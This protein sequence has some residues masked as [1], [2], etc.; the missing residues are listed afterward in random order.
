M[1]LRAMA[2]FLSG[3]SRRFKTI[4]SSLRN[5]FDPAERLVALQELSEVLSVS[6]EDSLAGYFP[7]E[8]FVKELIALL[9]GN[10]SD[11][12]IESGVVAPDSDVA[13][14][15]AAA[16][17][18]DAGDN[19]EI[20]LLAAR[21]LTNLMEAMPYATHSVVT[22]GAIPLLN[23]KLMF[24]EFI[25]LAEQVLQTLE[26]ISVD[27]PNAIVEE[28]GL[29]AM[30]QY[31]DFF[32]I[33][34][35]RTAMNAVSNCCR[36][37]NSDNFDKVKDAMSQ[38]QGM[39]AS[40]DRRLKE[41]AVRSVVR[42][43]DS[44]KAFPEILETLI[45]EDV[46][47]ATK[48]VLEPSAGSNGSSGAIISTSMYT[49][50]VK[51]LC[52]AS[53][54][55][56]QITAHL[57]QSGIGATLYCI[58]TGSKAADTGNL[59]SADPLSKPD[60]T[61]GNVS[62]SG[63]SPVVKMTLL[64][65][66]STKPKEQIQEALTLVC[67][68]LPPLPWTDI[69]D[70]RNYSEKALKRKKHELAKREGVAKG[71]NSL[72]PPTA[73]SQMESSEDTVEAAPTSQASQIKKEYR[74]GSKEAA[75][76]VAHARRLEM[77]N[78]QKDRLL[79]L[80]AMILPA[81]VDI[82]TASITPSIRSKAM[83][84]ILKILAFADA[85]QLEGLL[86]SVPMSTFVAGVLSSKDSPTV[87]QGSLQV[88]ELL[89]T[90]L[91][92]IY[93]ALL[94]REGV[95]WEVKQLAKQPVSD[96]G[97]SNKA[98]GL[99]ADTLST[100]SQNTDDSP[101]S[102][103][104]K[105]GTVGNSGLRQV[106]DANVL[107]ARMV[108]LVFGRHKQKT[109]NNTES[110]TADS[111]ERAS[112]L[113]QQIASGSFES[114]GAA[115]SCLH[116]AFA[117]LQSNGEGLSGF[118]VVKSGLI[119][120][121]L[122]FLN[123]D[124]DASLASRRKGLLRDTMKFMPESSR[125]LIQRLQESLS[126]LERVEMVSVAGSL[127]DEHRRSPAAALS[128]Q[129]RL[130]LVA[131]DPDGIPKSCNNIIVSIHAVA[132]FGSLHDFLRPK[133][134]LGNS[135]I[136]P[137]TSRLSS[138]L[139]AFAAAAQGQES[140]R[141]PTRNT[142]SLTSDGAS[143]ATATES[144]EAHTRGVASGQNSGSTTHPGQVT[145]DEQA[146]KT[147][148][149]EQGLLRGESA[150]LADALMQNLMH[151]DMDPLDEDLEELDI[152]EREIS[153][154]ESG[155][156]SARQLPGSRAEE[157]ETNVSAP[158]TANTS[159][160]EPNSQTKL[161]SYSEAVQKPATDWHLA[162]SVDG[163]DVGLP[164]TIFSAIYRAEKRKNASFSFERTIWQN[165]VTVRFRKVPGTR[166]RDHEEIYGIAA[167]K[168]PAVSSIFPEDSTELKILRL[169]EVLYHAMSSLSRHSS[170]SGIRHLDTSLFINNKLTA[171]LNRQ[172]EEPL[173]V[174]S[175]SL[176][177]WAV[178]LPLEYPFLFP[179]ETRFSFLQSTSFGYARLIARWQLLH[180]GSDNGRNEDSFGFLSRLQRQKVRISRRRLLDSAVKIFDLYASNSS[181][182]EVE[183]FDEVG[184]GLGP[185]LEFYSLVSQDF[186]LKE[187]NIWLD[188]Q[189]N[190]QSLHVSAAHG[191]YPIPISSSASTTL[192][193]SKRLGLF[194]TLGTFVAKALLDSR[195][196]QI[197]FS[198]LFI[199]AILGRKVAYN[200]DT[201][202]QVDGGLASSLKAIQS[203]AP[204]DV[205]TLHL[206]FTLPGDSNYEL[207]PGGSDKKVS[208]NNVNDYISAV[209]DAYLDSGIQPVVESFRAGFE[210]VFMLSSLKPFTADEL[211]L[212][213]GN[214]QEDW[215]A[216]TLLS[217]IKP[218]HGFTPESEPYRNLLSIM[219][220]FTDQ[221]RRTFLQ[222]L[223]GSPKLPIGG[224]KALHPQ[225]TVVK[226]PHEAPLKPDDYLPSVMTCVN[227]LKLPS[228]SGKEVMRQRLNTAM[229]EGG[230]AFHLS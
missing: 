25:D 21:C 54:A 109:P 38:I 172:L 126:R 99:P 148:Q 1:N 226:R 69:F 221:E 186:A 81:L 29:M 32:N 201:L 135:L 57:L 168:Q 65:N 175:T 132:S 68:L 27:Y 223:T 150:S 202:A 217:N 198:R 52:N 56:P 119:N 46:C 205:A 24:I 93:C 149:R 230:T 219:Q 127:D 50:L 163:E 178:G 64:Q 106:K 45:T 196:V 44:Y 59:V 34:V 166:A 136:G 23:S 104:P 66:L 222:W 5:R 180:R 176:P 80:S 58:L 49:D 137:G 82:H 131:D 98:I 116:S 39:L 19:T 200:L 204:E 147:L 125:N 72:E 63:Q 153:P 167:E 18:A 94:E 96:T 124:S 13:A 101:A 157:Q 83:T 122:I 171:K 71:R 41:S 159:T 97:M 141:E 228:Y 206:D 73:N 87:I 146:D 11:A 210:K 195:I 79:K 203:V 155:D 130:R 47:A 10:P 190:P 48:F 70:Q 53:K 108:H 162:F 187:N 112:G 118:E 212:L 179:F 7:T 197:D 117:L 14:A 229:L 138:V 40:P 193:G 76:Q 36:K 143:T 78:E 224:F 15:L 105:L 139:A 60:E 84:A 182:L 43:I 185:T 61:I 62:I 133:I 183:Y 2:G 194:R 113:A 37:L 55:T 128:K 173:I 17:A 165:L 192:E 95:M 107:R 120:A 20:M 22:N 6:S 67:E 170:Q 103:A 145:S 111:L 3:L 30:L 90:K 102:E 89:L 74:K 191:L 134:A 123:A 110:S 225:L 91:G 144:V 28:G 227:Y 35:Q 114:E 188:E 213:F 9:G 151:D 216:E 42:I 156:P 12:S 207:V 75:A 184:T 152:I 181:I 174:A 189:T 160:A 158:D 100:E 31:I 142:N 208:G 161:A 88:V 16:D 4:L 115:A 218:D 33:H 177:D 8:S 92:H 129:I 85:S 220:D 211:V 140:P 77:L 199:S 86:R 164:E 214:S 51:A 215:S 169:L 209:I 26:K 154:P 121:L